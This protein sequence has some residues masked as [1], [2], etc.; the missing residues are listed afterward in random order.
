MT[1]KHLFLLIF[2]LSSFLL[3]AQNENKLIRDGNKKFENEKFEEA[4]ILYRRALEKNSNNYKALYNLSNALYKQSRY[5]EA[6]SILDGLSKMEVKNIDKS[7]IYHNLGNAQLNTH[8]IK[9]SIESYKKAL[10]KTPDDQDTRYNLAYAM[11]LLEEQEEECQDEKGNDEDEDK[12]EQEDHQASQND[13][14]KPQQDDTQPKPDKL[15][16]EEAQRI[17]DALNQEEQ[18]IQE[19]INREESDVPRIKPEKEW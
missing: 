13:K 16:Q 11:N 1:S 3:N 6:I 7:N 8:Q 18:K 17:L 9:E 12:Q 15:S 14:E 2:L 10:K 5:D 19:K 4:E